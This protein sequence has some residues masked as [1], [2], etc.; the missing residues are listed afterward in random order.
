MVVRNNSM[1][2]CTN[3]RY[4]ILSPPVGIRLNR[5]STISTARTTKASAR[6]RTPKRWLHLMMYLSTDSPRCVRL[7]D[8]DH[9]HTAELH[10]R[11]RESDRS[12][13][14]SD[15]NMWPRVRLGR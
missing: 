5:G 6:A 3:A 1:A 8:H 12:E 9:E 14:C 11:G 15:S 7:N 4:P 13:G 2:A 10:E